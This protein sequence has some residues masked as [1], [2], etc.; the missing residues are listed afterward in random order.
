ML[1]SNDRYRQNGITI[2]PAT[3]HAHDDVKIIYNGLLPQSGAA[4]VWAHV[5]YGETWENAHD[6][7]MIKTWHDFETVVPVQPATTLNIA[8]KDCAGNWDNNSGN[9]YS[10]V[11][12]R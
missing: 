8:F 11:I 10:F 7:P 1:N 4:E 12:D 3:P 6:Y 5:G 2:F 9:N